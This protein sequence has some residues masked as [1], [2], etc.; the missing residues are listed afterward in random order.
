MQSAEKYFTSWRLTKPSN[1]SSTS[2]AIFNPRM[3]SGIAPTS[4]RY[5]SLT[6]PDSFRLILLQPSSSHSTDL[7]ST[8]LHTTLFQCDGDIIDHY[9]ALSY[10]W[11]DP[12]KTGSIYV[13]EHKF[14]IT[15]TLEAALRDLRDPS[16]ML[17]IWA[18]AL[19]IDQSNMTERNSQVALMA[20]IY[21]IAH[22]TVIHLG[23]LTESYEIILR[24]APSNTTG[25]VSNEIPIDDL[26]GLAATSL[27][28]LPWFSRVWIFQELVL[29]RD[30]W[31]QCGHLRARW[32]D[33]CNILVPAGVVSNPSGRPKELQMLADMNF[34][35][36]GG[37]REWLF[38]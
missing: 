28:R 25:V 3:A 17:R 35:R 30:P 9:T 10:V 36:V 5:R 26:A 37:G 34:A 8:L 21:S 16:R 33:I 7:Q 12:T 11:G 32:T 29:S 2:I 23:S 6:E 22:H 38:S 20:Q 4:F 24:A 27:L 19:C 13:D 1:T 18:D 31:L 14:T 15:A